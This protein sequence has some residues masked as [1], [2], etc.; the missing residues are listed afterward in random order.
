MNRAIGFGKLGFEFQYKNTDLYLKL[1]DETKI[2]YSNKLT[3]E[4]WILEG[5]KVRYE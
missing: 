4:K 2:G 1:L 3:K 5:N